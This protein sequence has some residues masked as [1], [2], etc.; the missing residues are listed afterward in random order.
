MGKKRAMDSGHITESDLAKREE[1]RK[2]REA[3][4]EMM[5][6][7]LDYVSK[8]LDEIIKDGHDMTN[9]YYIR[10]VRVSNSP[11][12]YYNDVEELDDEISVMA[13][14]LE[15][16]AL[17]ILKKYFHPDLSCN[18]RRISF[19]DDP[20]GRMLKG[21]AFHLNH[22]FFEADQIL[23]VCSDLREKA[24]QEE[25]GLIRVFC[26]RLAA[27]LEKMIEDNRKAD[28]ISVMGP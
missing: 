2:R 14:Y 26:L 19:D 4:K 28:V 24:S 3:F 23:G 15:E 22:N 18:A 6:H 7:R 25:D 12:V 5:E 20:K 9:Y 8:D 13:E 10:P 21:F 11:T 16:Y 17:P 27:R 1:K